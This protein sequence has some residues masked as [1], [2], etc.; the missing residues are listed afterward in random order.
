ML[1]IK[2]DKHNE[3]V[4][5]TLCNRKVPIIDGRLSNHRPEIGSFICN[6]SGQANIKLTED[7][8]E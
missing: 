8:Y 2:P 6:G 1:K 4:K 7:H 5:C 3:L